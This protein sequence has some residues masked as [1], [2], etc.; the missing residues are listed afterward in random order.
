MLALPTTICRLL[1]A[2]CLALP[3]A[4]LALAFTPDGETAE[5]IDFGGGSG[6]S[7]G[8]M[9]VDTTTSTS[10]ADESYRIRIAAL[11]IRWSS[12]GFTLSVAAGH[13]SYSDF[14]L[15]GLA[16]GASHFSVV[17]ISQ[18]LMQVA[19]GALIAEFSARRVLLGDVPDVA[20]G[21]R[22]SKR[23]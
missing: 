3:P 13:R 23:F 2:F 5:L 18:E 7:L 21:L 22:W 16:S 1:L 14:A 6:L 10:L 11:A 20:V 15:S 4:A 9:G 8:L 12:G 19:S 17:E